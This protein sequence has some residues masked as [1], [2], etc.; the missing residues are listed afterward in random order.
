VGGALQHLRLAEARRLMLTENYDA[1][2]AG[3]RVGYE[4]ASQFSREY[5]RRFDTQKQMSNGCEDVLKSRFLPN[6]VL[7]RACQRTAD[8]KSRFSPGRGALRRVSKF[9]HT[10]FFGQ[11]AQDE[12]TWCCRVRINKPSSDPDARNQRA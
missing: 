6:G 7:S 4:D 2:Q 8:G 10:T 1:A 12:P 11:H 9:N 5:R 3:F